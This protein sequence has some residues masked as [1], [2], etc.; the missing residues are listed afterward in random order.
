MST[1]RANARPVRPPIDIRIPRGEQYD[2]LYC[3]VMSPRLAA[4][5]LCTIVLAAGV[6]SCSSNAQPTKEFDTVVTGD[7]LFEAYGQTENR[8]V[9]VSPSRMAQNFILSMDC[10]SPKGSIRIRLTGMPHF[11][12]LGEIPCGEKPNRNGP[13]GAIG[14]GLSDKNRTFP[15]KVTIAVTAP[16]GG[17]W[18]AAVDTRASK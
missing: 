14:I 17:K 13:D 1:T 18:S 10:I 5:L 15:A 3:V 2:S 7:R 9:V 16:K 4:G 8:S 12:A 6:S 11:E